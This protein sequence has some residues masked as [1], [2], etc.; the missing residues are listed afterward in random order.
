MRANYTEERL[1]IVRGRF[2]SESI[3]AFKGSRLRP[4]KVR[5]AEGSIVP[6][7]RDAQRMLITQLIDKGLVEPRKAI[8]AMQSGTADSLIDS[9]E[10]DVAKANREIQQ[11]VATG[12]FEG[13][14]VPMVDETADD[15]Q[16]HLE[17]CTNWMKTEDFES[18]PPFVQEA[19]KAHAQW[20]E[21]V[22]QQ[23]QM[24]AA[25][26]QSAAATQLGAQNAASPQAPKPMPSQPSVKTSAEGAGMVSGN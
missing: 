12:T 7:T 9:Y 3:R 1:M 21:T 8:A 16:V 2:G 6:R 5:V 26:A 19:A 20:H 22:L 4:V 24:E 14:G 25:A 15:H 10:L 23:R 11:M 17:V 13:S 18:Q